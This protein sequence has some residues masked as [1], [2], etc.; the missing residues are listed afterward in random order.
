MGRKIVSGELGI[1][2]ADI[3][4]LVLHDA[5]TYD[6]STKTG[7]FSGSIRFADEP[8]RPGNVGLAPVVSKLEALQKELQEETGLKITFAD[9]E[10]FAG[11]MI[12]AQDFKATLCSK[13]KDC[14]TVYNAYGNKPSQLRLGRQDSSGPDPEGRV[15]WVGSS[16]GDFKA[17]FKKMRLSVKDLCCLAPALFEDE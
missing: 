8:K 9:T 15:P 5:I 16:V 3:T 1:S 17:A 12:S 13:V 4:R 7:G 2:L 14:D 6:P 10:A 11:Q